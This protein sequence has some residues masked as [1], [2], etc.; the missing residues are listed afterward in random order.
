[1]ENEFKYALVSY[2]NRKQEIL[3]NYRNE[4][5]VLEDIK[6]KDPSSFFIGEVATGKGITIEEFI[7][8]FDK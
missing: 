8:K 3:R 2:C 1:M 6:F 4:E 7:S 5:E